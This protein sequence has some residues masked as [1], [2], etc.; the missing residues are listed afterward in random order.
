[1]LLL[2]PPLLPLLPFPA[3][4]RAI[5]LTYIHPFPPPLFKQKQLLDKVRLQIATPLF[6]INHAHRLH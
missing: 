3:L 5:A 2:P 1:L 6:R 4:L